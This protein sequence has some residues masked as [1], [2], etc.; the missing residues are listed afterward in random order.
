MINNYTSIEDKSYD[1][2]TLAKKFNQRSFT[3]PIDWK[4][5]TNAFN[6]SIVSDILVEVDDDIRDEVIKLFC[7]LYHQY[8]MENTGITYQNNEY[9]NY[10]CNLNWEIELRNMLSQ[11]L[12]NKTM[13]SAFCQ[14]SDK[15]NKNKKDGH[16]YP[17]KITVEF[18]RKL[19]IQ[20]NAELFCKLPNKH[21][22]HIIHLITG[23]SDTKTNS[24]LSTP[25]DMLIPKKYQQ[26]VQ[27]INTTLE[28]YGFT[29]ALL[30]CK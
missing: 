1:I 8:C 25:E 30:S 14:S 2:G 9:V 13:F 21:K 11:K 22:A 12:A 29:S 10:S 17:M 28:K 6:L 16:P 27:E 20:E 23:F 3:T 15:T 4:E 24:L 19:L 26:E 7:G 18:I 5:A